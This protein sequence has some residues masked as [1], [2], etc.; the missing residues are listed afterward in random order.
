M[1]GNLWKFVNNCYTVTQIFWKLNFE[2]VCQSILLSNLNIWAICI[3]QSTLAHNNNHVAGGY[4]YFISLPKQSNLL[5]IFFPKNQS[6]LKSSL[7]S[8][9]NLNLT[10]TLHTKYSEKRSQKLRKYFVF[11]LSLKKH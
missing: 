2:S 11:G 1:T 4:W 3:R 10:F 7:Q 8:G 5:I 6:S 9:N